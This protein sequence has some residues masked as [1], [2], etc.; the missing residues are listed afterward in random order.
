MRDTTL[1]PAPLTFTSLHALPPRVTKLRVTTISTLL[2]PSTTT[3]ATA[4]FAGFL[5]GAAPSAHGTD[6]LG[7]QRCQ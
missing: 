1:S 5:G 6:P 7:R 3:S 2:E 4:E